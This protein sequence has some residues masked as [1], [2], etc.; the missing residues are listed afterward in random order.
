MRGITNLV[1]NYTSNFTVQQWLKFPYLLILCAKALRSLVRLAIPYKQGELL[2]VSLYFGNIIVEWS[3]WLP[4]VTLAHNSASSRSGGERRRWR[5][6][7]TGLP[8]RTCLYLWGS[9]MF[10]ISRIDNANKFLL[11]KV[12][13]LTLQITKD[14]TSQY[15]IIRVIIRL[16]IL[17]T[18]NT[19]Y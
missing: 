3:H 15:V 8:W 16:L 4:C 19:A 9:A 5:A 1:H 11:K 6:H 12:I 10:I 17:I 13:M 14:T 2:P 7:Q 18:T